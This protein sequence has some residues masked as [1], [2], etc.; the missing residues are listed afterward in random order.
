MIFGFLSNSKWY[1]QTAQLAVSQSVCH[2]TSKSEPSVEF[3][4]SSVWQ[5]LWKVLS[6]CSFVEI[7]LE[8]ARFSSYGYKFVGHL[9]IKPTNKPTAVSVEQNYW[10]YKHTTSELLTTVTAGS[11]LTQSLQFTVTNTVKYNSRNWQQTLC[12][13][14]V[15][16]CTVHITVLVVQ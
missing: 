8:T 6:K 14:N 7:C 9:N 16:L 11:D 4:W 2:V 1:L 5:L 3:S 13:H 15:T 12:D 10:Q